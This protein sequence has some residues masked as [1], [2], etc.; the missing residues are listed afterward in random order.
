MCSQRVWELSTIE[1]FLV[2]GRSMRRELLQSGIN[3]GNS[4]ILL[5]NICALLWTREKET[6]LHEFKRVTLEAGG[7]PYS[8][9]KTFLYL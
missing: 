9:K 7:N 1:G 6:R 3:L 5:S 8:K 4:G 2:F